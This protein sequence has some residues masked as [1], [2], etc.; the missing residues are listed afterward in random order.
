MLLYDV[1]LFI[2]S[3]TFTEQFLRKILMVSILQLSHT[4]VICLLKFTVQSLTQVKLR[5]MLPNKYFSKDSNSQ[6][7]RL[8]NNLLPSEIKIVC[9]SEY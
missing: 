6:R 9:D 1:I 3:T 8:L 7:G 5:T 2:P 4:E